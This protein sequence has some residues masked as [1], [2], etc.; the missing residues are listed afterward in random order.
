[1]KITIVSDMLKPFCGGSELYVESVATELIKRGHEVTWVGMRMPDT[2][3]LEILPSG[4]KIRRINVPFRND[5]MSSRRMFCFMPQ[6]FKATKDADVVQWNSFVS[7]ITG[8]VI[9]KLMNK[10]HILLNHEMFDGL[11]KRFTSNP[12]E[13]TVYPLMEKIIVMNRYD[14]GIVPCKNSEEDLVKL[15]MPRDKIKIIHHGIDHQNFRPRF[16]TFKEKYHLWDRFVLGWSGRSG[17]SGTAYSKNVK[18]LFDA[19]KQVK[20]KIPS[21]VLLMCG[22]GWD[23]VSWYPRSIGLEE[24]RDVIHVGKIPY[25]QMPELYSSLD[26]FVSSSIHEGFGLSIVE[27]QSCGTPVVA[28]DKAGSIPEVVENNKSGKLVYPQTSSRLV[29]GIEELYKYPELRRRM[30]NHAMQWTKQ[31]NWKD[32]AKAHEQVYEDVLCWHKINRS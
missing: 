10:P 17:F 13:Q 2:K 20:V 25:E 31:F 23:D 14:A 15:G 5:Y 19:F 22:T 27:A 18:C 29:K 6:L 30:G 24:G 9:S 11:W 1:M 21:A 12:I 28:F 16:A 32:S 3:E 4:I 26:V 8:G 7:A